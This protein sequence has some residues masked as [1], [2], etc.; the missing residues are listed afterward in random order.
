MIMLIKNF[1][2]SLLRFSLVKLFYIN[3][4][5]L[6]F[7]NDKNINLRSSYQIIHNLLINKIKIIINNQM[8]NYLI[9]QSQNQEYHK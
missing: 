1:Y 4:W 9:L 3:Y 5:L 6:Y 8:R 7:Y 2:N